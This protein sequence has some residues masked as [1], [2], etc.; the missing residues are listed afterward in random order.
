MQATDRPEEGE[1]L[2]PAVRFRAAYS[3]RWGVFCPLDDAGPSELATCAN[4]LRSSVGRPMLPHERQ[5]STLLAVHM[6]HEGQCC[7]RS[8]GEALCAASGSAQLAQLL[9]PPPTDPVT[10]L[11]LLQ[12]QPSSS[13]PAPASAPSPN[14]GLQP[15]HRPKPERWRAQNLAQ[16]SSALCIGDKWLTNGVLV[17]TPA[18]SVGHHMEVLYDPCNVS[19]GYTV[20]EHA[21]ICANAPLAASLQPASAALCLSYFEIT[22]L[23]PPTEGFIGELIYYVIV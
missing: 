12:A 13:P 15:G 6:L 18:A 10:A 5:A 3:R 11:E 1:P 14:A 9:Y 2:A 20:R 7:K 23:S 19:G 22:V 21:L 4:D 17:P 8:L 16:N